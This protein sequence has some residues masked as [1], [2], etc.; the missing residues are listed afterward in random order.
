MIAVI[1]AITYSLQLV[2][3]QSDVLV[4]GGLAIVVLSLYYIVTEFN[5]LFTHLKSKL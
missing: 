3:S 1:T 2:N 4:F 5:K